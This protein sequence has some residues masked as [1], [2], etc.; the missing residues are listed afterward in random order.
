[1]TQETV[2]GNDQD[3]NAAKPADQAT[4]NALPAELVGLVGEGKKYASVDEA[5]RSVPHKEMHIGKLETENEKL[6][7]ELEEKQAKLDQAKQIDD[8]LNR[9]NSSSEEKVTPNSK[10][11]DEGAIAQRVA[12]MLKEENAQTVANNNISAVDSMMKEKYGEE[13]AK[14]LVKTKAAELGVGVDFLM[15]MAAKSPKAFYTQMGIDQP[16]NAPK[17]IN[18]SNSVN[19][20]TMNQH[21]GPEVGT[22]AYYNALRKTDPKKW[23]SADVQVAMWNA[24]RKDPTKFYNS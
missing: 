10:Q 15:T 24:A 23:E 17:Q 2:F 11:L 20:E 19:T 14:E 21:S 1:M 16:Q 5:L 18:T 6:R 7:R 9:M 4:P 8:I 22:Y 13:K 12:L 3:P